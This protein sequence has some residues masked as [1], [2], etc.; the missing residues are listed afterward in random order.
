[1]GIGSPGELALR[2]AARATRCTPALPRCTIGRHR[3]R[4]GL[5]GQGRPT[6]EQAEEPVTSPSSA[7]KAVFISYSSQDVDAARR[8]AAALQQGGIEVW[9]DQSELRGGEAWDASI[10]RQIKGCK[11]FLAVISASTQAREEGYFRREWNLAVQRTLDMAE[12]AAF[13]LPVV[14]DATPDATARVPEKFRDVQWTR[15]PGGETPARFVERVH[16]LVGANAAPGASELAP[17]GAPS[18]APGGVAPARHEPARRELRGARRAPPMAAGRLRARLAVLVPVLL[19]L[20]GGALLWRQWQAKEHARS[21]LLPAVQEQAATMFRSNRALFDLATRAEAALPGDPALARLWPAIATTLSIETEPAGAEVFWKD[22]DTPSA[23][24]RSAGVTPLKAVKV[25]RDFL[26]LEVRKAGYQTIELAEPSFG[27]AIRPIVRKLQLDKQGSLPENMV[28]I[29]PA[30]AE[31]AIIGIEKYGP[32]EV[33]GFLVDKYE[34]TNRQFKAFM[35]AGGYAN[36]ALWIYP[37]LEGGK[38]VPLQAA[39]ARFKDRTGRPGPATWEAGSYPDGTADHPVTGVSWYEAAAYAA[40]VH[41]QLPSVFQWAVVADTSRSE[42]LLP[43]SNFSGKG[44]SAV[45]SL[46]GFSTYGVYDVG[47]NAREWTYNRALSGPD[48][49]EQRFVLGGGWSDPTYAFNDGST[50]PALDRG[51]SNGFRCVQELADD[52]TAATLREPLAMDFRDYAKERPVDDA[53]FAGY[54]RQF[55]YDKAPLAA[56]IEQEEETDLWKEQVVSIDAGYNNERLLLHVYLPKARA[57][58]FQPVV[59]Y[60]G[61]NGIFESKYDPAVINIRLQFIVKS[62]RA[63]VVPIN[64][65]TFER[66]DGLKTDLQEPTAR[67][68]DHVVMWVKEYSRTLDYLETRKDMRAERAAYLGISWGG[69][70]GG[71]IPAIEKRFK[72]VVLNVGGMEMEKALPEVDQINY[73]PRVTQPVLMLNGSYDMYFPVESAQKPMYRMLGT[74]PARKKMLVYSSGHLVPPT[75]FIK[76][77]LGWLDTWLGPVD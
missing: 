45:G 52:A 22:Y 42:F 15:L 60:S 77:T 68:R 16:G 40:F 32:R 73:L 6:H 1:L 53:T 67:Y 14:I 20:L 30:T 56:K 51:E 3:H 72:A 46:A 57:G 33:P 58:P 66:Q 7:S 27:L 69:F 18:S 17:A 31:M 49:P 75:E 63:L 44:T 8:I 10:R 71:I 74:P 4:A 25:P 12:D 19:L 36:P 26:R 5:P 61:S 2:I 37:I 35:D 54:A 28:R 65:G 47:G 43:L 41:K 39:L 55:V 50:Q 13:L 34:V 9:L 76:E 23:E 24:W 48:S 29:P 70:M 11:L 21:V 38:A 64:K 62:G 59:F